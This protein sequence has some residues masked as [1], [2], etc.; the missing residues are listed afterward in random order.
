[1]DPAPLN[2]AVNQFLQAGLLGAAVLILGAVIIAQWRD[3][4]AERVEFLKQIHDLQRARIDDGKAVQTQ[5]LEVV[6]QCTQALVT[7]TSTL[8]GQRDAMTELRNAFRDLGEEMR[9]LRDSVRQQPPQ[10]R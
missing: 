5:M 1:M 8:E 3:A 10:K 6:K 9:G 7:V 2:T 4:K